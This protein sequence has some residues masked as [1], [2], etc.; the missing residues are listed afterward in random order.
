MGWSGFG[1]VGAWGKGVRRGGEGA[2][3]IECL[4]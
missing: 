4:G 3:I 1:V 2:W